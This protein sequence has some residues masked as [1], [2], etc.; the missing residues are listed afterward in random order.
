MEHCNVCKLP[1]SEI[2]NGYVCPNGHITQKIEEVKDLSNCKG[3]SALVTKRKSTKYKLRDIIP[4]LTPREVCALLGMKYLHALLIEFEIPASAFQRYKELYYSFTHTIEKTPEIKIGP[5]YRK[6]GEVFIFLVKRDLEEKKGKLFTIHDFMRKLEATDCLRVYYLRYR[7]QIKAQ[8][9]RHVMSQNI[10]YRLSCIQIT[11]LLQRTFPNR[12]EYFS[13]VFGLMNEHGLGVMCS[14]LGITKT[15]SLL[16]GFNSFKETL[17]H[18]RFYEKY[19]YFL[20]SEL[21]IGVYLYM[22]FM[23]M[24]SIVPVKGHFFVVE[25]A[26]DVGEGNVVQDYFCREYN[27]ASFK[28]INIYMNA[29]EESNG[30]HAPVFNPVEFPAPSFGSEGD[31]APMKK[32]VSE[33]IFRQIGQSIGGSITVVA[34]LTKRIVSTYKRLVYRLTPR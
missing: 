22:Y 18:I 13:G 32:V 19:R 7:S 21:L 15:R 2:D 12:K 5:E 9:M 29:L 8:Y 23:Q 28:Q 17:I 1:V 24:C 4:T 20:F 14:Q 6:I 30:W 27:I 26:K 16:D 34:E 25:N 3:P 33:K 11:K 31:R 10:A